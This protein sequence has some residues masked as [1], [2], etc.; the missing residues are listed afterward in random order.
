MPRNSSAIFTSGAITARDQPATPAQVSARPSAIT[1]AHAVIAI[2]Q[3]KPTARGAPSCRTT[4]PA[5]D[6]TPHALALIRR[7]IAKSISSNCGPAD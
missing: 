7:V 4:A 5:A 3:K 2:A 6:S 1:P